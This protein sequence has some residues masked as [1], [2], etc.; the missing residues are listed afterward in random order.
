MLEQ[1][2]IFEIPHNVWY[3]LRY[4]RETTP[5]YPTIIYIMTPFYISLI[6]NGILITLENDD[7]ESSRVYA[8]A[9]DKF[10]SMSSTELLTVLT[11]KSMAEIMASK[12]IPEKE[13]PY[14]FEEIIDYLKSGHTLDL[15]NDELTYILR[16]HGF[17]DGTG[18]NGVHSVASDRLLVDDNDYKMV[19][20][21]ITG[22]DYDIE[23]EQDDE[24]V[25]LQTLAEKFGYDLVKH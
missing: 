1:L 8:Y 18:P 3:D 25:L 5:E 21:T 15:N 19:F 23:S 7:V 17:T 4:M 20:K 13:I 22:V 16:F 11:G 6:D 2:G 14:D 24:F 10:R 9:T 12:V